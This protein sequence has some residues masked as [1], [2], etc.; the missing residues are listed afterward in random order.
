MAQLAAV[1]GRPLMPWQRAALR[2]G[3]ELTAPGL[4]AH[5]TVALSAG[6][7][8]GKTDAAILANCWRCLAIPGTRFR[9]TAQTRHDAAA[10]LLGVGELLMRSPFASRIR[11]YRGDGGERIQFVNGSSATVFSAQPDAVHG[12]DTDVVLID[13]CWVFDEVRGRELLAAT[14]PS[15]ATRR[16]PQLW[17]ISAAGTLASTWW[18]AQMEAAR[19]SGVLVDFGLP[20]GAEL[21]A[22]NIAGSHPAVGHTIDAEAIE[23]AA[24]KMPEDEWIRAFANRPTGSL[25]A[26]FPAAL[27]ERGLV[28]ALEAPVLAPAAIGVDVAAD[29]SAA[30]VYSAELLEDGRVLVE[31]VRV[32]PG[33]DWVAPLLDAFLEMPAVADRLVGVGV[34]A[35]GPARPLLTELEL[36]GRLDYRTGSNPG[37][38]LVGFGAGYA[39]QGHAQFYDLVVAG[40]LLHRVDPDLDAAAAGVVLTPG[41][42]VMTISRSRSAAPVWPLLAAANA[43]QALVG[44]RQT[45]VLAGGGPTVH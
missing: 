3:L 38:L 19:A 21:T 23:A 33:V 18:V 41:R 25:A 39:S 31:Q 9:M 12:G 17:L 36:T 8:S 24:G 26:L 35:S 28:A 30:A 43:V 22:E 40:R 2:V 5:G 4:L 44:S 10:S 13:E 1:A 32:A 7:R 37:G 15:M 29:R 42:P 34:E 6:R 16:S 45:H 11:L 27:W 14:V 20:D